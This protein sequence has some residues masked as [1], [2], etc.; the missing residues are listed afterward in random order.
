MAPSQVTPRTVL[1]VIVTI[2]AVVGTLFLLW[3]LRVIVRWTV[4]ALFLAVAMNPAVNRL[5]S[6]RVPRALAILILYLI[7]LFFL[8]GIGALVVPP[9]VQQGQALATYVMGLYDQRDGL[10]VQVRDLAA[11]YGLSD[12]LNSLQGQLST[13]PARLSAAAVP[14]LSVA[15][16]VVG[17]IYASITIL[18]LTFFLLLDGE[19]FVNAGLALFAVSERP[20]LRKL[21]DQASGAVSGYITGNLLIS[22]IAGFSTFIFLKLPFVAMP[23]AVILALIVALFD[24]VPLVGATI[25][26]IVVSLVGLFVDPLTGIILIVFFLIYQQIENNI[27]QPLVY[28]RSVR[29]HPLVIFLAVLAGGELLGILGALLAIPVAE[30]ARILLADWFDRRAVV[31]AGAS[32]PVGTRR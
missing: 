25:G 26:A 1:L 18:L 11:Q 14:L 20:R 8:I 32:E 13:L 29:L 5:Q 7:L 22:L 9:L 10:I 4:I 21:L 27:L 17:S 12:A 31:A 28:G 2:L 6:L 15:S 23:Y 24:L 3:Q 30:I 19:R 16:G